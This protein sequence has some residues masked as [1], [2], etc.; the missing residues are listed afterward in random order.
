[1][2]TE[3]VLRTTTYRIPVG[4]FSGGSYRLHLR[5]TLSVNYFVMIQWQL[6][7]SGSFGIRDIAVRVSEDPYGTN[8]LAQSGGNWITLL[9]E[10]IVAGAADVIVTVVE[11]LRDEDGAGFRLRDVRVIALADASAAGVQ[12]TVSTSTSPW[13]APT[14]VV[15]FGGR[16]GGGI[17]SSAALDADDYPTLGMRLTASGTSTIT[18]ERYSPTA[19]PVNV[20]AAS[21]VVYAVE[22]GYEWT[23]QRE[24]VIGT[25]SGATL[26]LAGHYS[27]ATL[28]STVERSKSWLWGCGYTD[29]LGPGNS[30]AGQVY[31]LGDG[32]TANLAE[33]TVAVGCCSAITVRSWDVWVMTHRHLVAEYDFKATAAGPGDYAFPIAAQAVGADT[34]PGADTL[35]VPGNA[36]SRFGMLQGA[37][38]ASTLTSQMGEV[39]Y[40]VSVTS[41]LVLQARTRDP[42]TTFAWAGWATTVDFAALT[43]ESGALPAIRVS[44]IRFDSDLTFTGTTYDLV[45]PQD[46]S[47]NYFVMI[48]GA[49]IVS[50]TADPDECA[51]YVLQDP[52]GTGDLAVSTGARVIRLSRTAA[53]N[54]WRGQVTVVECLRGATGPGF[55]LVD[56]RFLALP[57]F[58]DTGVQSVTG[59]LTPGQV[60]TDPD[61]VTLIAGHRGGGIQTVGAH[62]A[63]D[64]QSLGVAAIPTGTTGIQAYRYTNSATKLL[65]V[66]AVVYAVEWGAEWTVQS[67]VMMGAAGGTGVDLA[68]EYL[69]ARLDT[70]VDPAKTWLWASLAAEDDETLHSYL[71]GSVHLGDGVVQASQED[72]VSVGL[73]AADAFLAVVYAMTHPGLLNGWDFLVSNP[74]ASVTATVDNPLRG[75]QYSVFPL[76]STIGH[77]LG[78]AYTAASDATATAIAAATLL[79]RHT[80]SVNLVVSRDRI[81]GSFAGWVQSVDFG[82]L[83]AAVGGIQVDD[84][85]RPGPQG[86]IIFQDPRW[87]GAASISS[88]TSE[89]GRTVGPVAPKTDN[90]GVVVGFQEGTPTTDTELSLYMTGGGVG[91]SG[92]YLYR[93]A[94]ETTAADWKA[95]NALT[96]LWRQ[97]STTSI[98]A[99]ATGL[100]YAQDV[101]YSAVY[102]RLLLAYIRSADG[103]IRVD[104]QAAGAPLATWTNTVISLTGSDAADTGTQAGLGMCELPDGSLLLIYQTKHPDSGFLNVNALASEDGGTTWVIKGRNILSKTTIS[105]QAATGGQYQVRNSGDWVRAH[106]ISSAAPYSAATSRTIVSADRGASWDA[107][108]N[109]L[110]VYSWMTATGFLGSAAT[111]MVGLGDASGTFLLAYQDAAGSTTVKIAIAAR[112]DDWNPVSALNIDISSY[113]TTARLKGA[114]FVREPDRLWLF[115]WVEGTNTADILSVVCT[116]PTDPENAASWKVLGNLSGFRGALRYG[117][118]C[119]RGTWAGNRIVLSGGIQNPDVAAAADPLIAGHWMVQSGSWDVRPWDYTAVD[120]YY[121]DYLTEGARMTEYQWI[122]CSGSPAGDAT[123]SDA[124]T[125]WTRATTGVVTYT[126]DTRYQTITTSDATGVGYYEINPSTAAQRS[127]WGTGRHGFNFRVLASSSRGLVSGAV[128][129]I[130]IRIKALAVG[131]AD[132]RDFTIR[133]SPIGIAIWDE[134]LA[135][136]LYSAATTTPASEFE[137]RVGI[138][139]GGIVNIAWRP[140]SSAPLGAWTESPEVTVSLSAF[141]AQ[142]CRVGVLAAPGAGTSTV[143][144]YEIEFSNPETDA[145]QCDNVVKPDH[146]VGTKL[147]YGA[148]L[149]ANG[150][151]L[152]WGGSGACEGDEFTATLEYTRGIENLSL[153]SPR[154]YWESSSLVK[155]EVVFQS[156]SRSTAPRWVMN[157]MLLVGTTDRTCTLNFSNTNT[158]AAWVAPA[159]S[160]ELSADL[161]TDLTVVAVDGSAFKVEAAIGSTFAPRRGELVGAYARFVASGTGTGATFRIVTD[162]EQSGWIHV[163]AAVDLA[164]AGIV[165]G[166]KVAIYG[167]RMV[168]LGAAFARYHFF[169][170]VFPDLS[171]VASSRGTYTGTHRIGSMVPGFH[172]RLVVPMEWSFRD[173][174]QPNLSEF[175]TKGGASWQY[176]EGPAQRVIDGRLVGDADEFRRSLRDMMREFQGYARSPVGLVLNAAQIGR[177]TVVFGRLTS[178][179]QMDESAWYRDAAGEWRTAGDVDL[180]LTEEV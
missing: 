177:E 85:D 40:A 178:G 132:G 106:Y 117:P 71:S 58:V 122:A 116:N 128:S 42:A 37:S 172:Q 93:L 144:V 17:S 16:N 133:I 119:F 153:D 10:S 41:G 69:T 140:V 110:T 163:D 12:T 60:Y 179:S 173:N 169:Q 131:A 52:F 156:D 21:A 171:T 46:L 146:L 176:E 36:G 29:G 27:T 5:N 89:G 73:W 31:T 50:A 109:S 154:Y 78:M 49:T 39:F 23:V 65:Q 51:V 38:I 61:R 170:V 129:D 22:W 138:R 56:V 139:T 121:N 115:L 53:V 57:A 92:G 11:C 148:I 98:G 67:M 175:R 123:N 28:K 166:A 141:A 159:V 2:A 26:D 88:I 25:N 90:Q 111:A 161:Y 164:G 152:R 34:Y 6:A 114:A 83:F 30:A 143:Q 87:D 162:V 157:A 120:P 180:V 160:V 104:Y 66:N 97:C 100:L 126:W 107:L 59:T 33:T 84:S 77:R 54:P 68:S 95:L 125:P 20:H 43:V 134:A 150:Q 48:E 19:V 8:D 35:Y 112:D 149:V 70:A 7:N 82:S 63:G 18:V 80:A 4:D 15:L 14:R 62:I 118:H 64:I 74:G 142:L 105:G 86:Y 168:Y 165:V 47:P 45:L 44:A 72:R 91:G 9:R 55:R 99:P 102:Q 151:R 124:N 167:D 158:A 147:N 32:V 145:G 3:P 155:Q 127:R 24:T 13:V 174:E 81:D 130:G 103:T 75:E 76:T 79:P 94:T 96:A 108:P 1:M 137:L 135:T 113:A 101:A 136:V